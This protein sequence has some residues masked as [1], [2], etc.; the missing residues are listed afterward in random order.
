M[1]LTRGCS[2]GSLALVR[3]GDVAAVTASKGIIG[4]S[5]SFVDADRFE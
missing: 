5:S 4:C 3:R 2:R 1:M